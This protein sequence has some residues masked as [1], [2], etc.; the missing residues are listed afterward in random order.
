MS[1]SAIPLITTGDMMMMSA[2]DMNEVIKTGLGD[3]LLKT[4]TDRDRKIDRLLE[5]L[6]NQTLPGGNGTITI[7]DSLPVQIATIEDQNLKIFPKKPTIPGY[8]AAY[9][10]IT[11]NGWS[12]KQGF[13]WWKENYKNEYHNLVEKQEQNGSENEP[14]DAFKSAM[15][16]RKRTKEA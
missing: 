12:Y 14:F 4:K 10:M 5:V 9:N 1:Y 15:N 3:Q 7:S 8:D 13:N 16:Y 11:R 2:A 6:E